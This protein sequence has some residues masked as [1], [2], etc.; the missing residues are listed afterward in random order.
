MKE[1]KDMQHFVE[2]SNLDSKQNKLEN[3]Y[4]AII[5]ALAA[6]LWLCDIKLYGD[7]FRF[8]PLYLGLFMLYQRQYRRV[9]LLIFV[10][11]VV[12]ALVFILKK[13]F[14]YL[15]INHSDIYNG[16]FEMIARRPING[17]F[18]G[19]PSGHTA[20]AFLALGFAMNFYPKKWVFLFF[21]LA[22]FVPLSRVITTWH[23]PLQVIAGALIG[24][25]LGYF[26]TYFIDKIA[27]KEKI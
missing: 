4:F 17:E 7:I 10:S 15:A 25:I 24:L 16:L 11:V 27:K 8:L 5:I 22:L 19:F 21:I 14:A 9:L 6:G 23:T 1:N 3:I 12:V 20:P 2:S 13:T 18:S 26:L